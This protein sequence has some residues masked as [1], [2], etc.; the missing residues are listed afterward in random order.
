LGYL[1]IDRVAIDWVCICSL[2]EE[3]MMPNK[4]LQPPPGNA[5]S[6]ANAGHVVDPEMEQHSRRT[7][8]RMLWLS[9]CR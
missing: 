8:Q 1:G 3:K 2:S 9:F 5:F 6:S 7:A 4:S